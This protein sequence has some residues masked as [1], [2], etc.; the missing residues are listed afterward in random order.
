LREKVFRN[1]LIFDSLI[2]GFLELKDLRAAVRYLRAGLRENVEISSET[3]LRVVKVCTKVL[4]FRAGILLLQALLGQWE[5]ESTTTIAY[6]SQARWAVQ[7]LFALCG[8]EASLQ[9][10]T[11]LRAD[12]SR[13]AVVNLQ[14]HMT[15]QSLEKKLHD[16]SARITTIRNILASAE[17]E[18]CREKITYIKEAL[19]VLNGA[20]FAE[21]ERSRKGR[22]Y[23]RID[24][25]LRQAHPSIK[26]TA[27]GAPLE[28]II[29]LEEHPA[30]EKLKNG[31]RPASKQSPD[32]SGLALPWTS[33]TLAIGLALTPASD[34]L[35]IEVAAS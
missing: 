7:R 19:M 11:P 13:A 28:R 30:Q 14:R 16:F 3:L 29:P 24:V 8:I 12:I 10:T 5:G 34:S 18:C 17:A 22:R 26:S 33:P 15:I 23:D 4:D 32:D 27:D 1:A 21:K 20:S 6:C 35:R 25:A 2:N 9:A 31:Y